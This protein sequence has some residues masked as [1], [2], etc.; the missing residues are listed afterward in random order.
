MF[1]APAC[2]APYPFA[3]VAPNAFA[4]GTPNAFVCG[5]VAD[6]ATAGGCPIMGCVLAYP[7]G[8]VNPLGAPGAVGRAPAT[9]A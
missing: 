1:A 9:V 7:V 2:G 3:G 6:I 4:G 8:G 5:A